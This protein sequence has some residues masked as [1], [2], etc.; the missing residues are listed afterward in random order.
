M[1]PAKP[2]SDPKSAP[3]DTQAK[4]AKSIGSEQKDQSNGKKLPQLG[5]LEDDDEF[6]VSQPV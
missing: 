1:D 3:V 2:N 4:D 6:E 5:A